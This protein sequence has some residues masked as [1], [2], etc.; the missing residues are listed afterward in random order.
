MVNHEIPESYVND[1]VGPDL[2]YV[3]DASKLLDELGWNIFT[4]IHQVFDT[5]RLI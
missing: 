4:N 2:R 1:R 5:H 3:I